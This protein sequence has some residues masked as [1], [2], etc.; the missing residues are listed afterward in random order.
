MS[1]GL[2]VNE[3]TNQ[4]MKAEDEKKPTLYRR[5]IKYVPN[6]TTNKERNDT[7][8]G[9]F[10]NSKDTFELKHFQKQMSNKL[11]ERA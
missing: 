6:T 11:I 7:K 10:F 5:F 1:F 2:N 4:A 3:L 8:V 9:S